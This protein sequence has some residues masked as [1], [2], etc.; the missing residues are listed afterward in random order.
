MPKDIQEAY[1]TPNRLVQITLPSYNSQHAKYIEQR[2]NI[3]R[4][5][6]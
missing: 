4:C 1:K 5:K 3:K 6:G 2:T